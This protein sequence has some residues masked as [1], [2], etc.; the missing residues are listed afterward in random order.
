KKPLQ[1]DE[2][3]PLKMKIYFIDKENYVEELKEFK[4]DINATYIQGEF[5][6]E[7]LE[8]YIQR[9]KVALK[10]AQQMREEKIK[11]LFSYG[12]MKFTYVFIVLNICLFL[13][14]ELFGSSTDVNTLI[15]F[16]AKYNPYIIDGQWWRLVSSMFLHVGF[17]HI[18]MNMLA[19]YFI[20]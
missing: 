11:T 5:V 20:G 13:L 19:L 3:N 12:K 16:G 8:A 7:E 17:I 2:K 1:L 18:L 15:R 9:Y 4:S 6:Q 14:T 10:K